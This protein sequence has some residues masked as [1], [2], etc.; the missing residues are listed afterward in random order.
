MTIRRNLVGWLLVLA[1]IIAVVAGWSLLQDT[2]DVP[3][4][5]A[6]LASGGIGG[7]VLIVLGVELVGQDDLRAIRAAVEELRDRFDDLEFDLA[8]TRAAV[9]GTDTRTRSTV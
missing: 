8:D 4:Q 9:R 3:V 1:G 5:V 6:Y 7:L 2:R